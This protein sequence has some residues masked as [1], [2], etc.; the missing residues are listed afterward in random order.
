MSAASVY[1]W[2][3]SGGIP[4]ILEL[5]KEQA[6]SLIEDNTDADTGALCVDTVRKKII[7]MTATPSTQVAQKKRGRKP[8]NKPMPIENTV[9]SGQVVVSSRSD[10]LFD[11]SSLSIPNLGAEPSKPTNKII[12]HSSQGQ[13]ACYYHWVLEDD[14]TL[15]LVYDSRFEFGVVF[16]PP[17]NG[18]AQIEPI[19]VTSPTNGLDML[20]HQ[21]G[22]DFDFGCFK[23]IGLVKVNRGA[24]DD[25]K[26]GRD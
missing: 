8:A 5:P 4:E 24:N 14:N 22:F 12:F 23:I 9:E 7:E 1:Q 18:P 26:D 10:R 17:M 15:F 11:F 2:A 16:T 13:I 6:I 20:C 21:H 3:V 25:G 19:R